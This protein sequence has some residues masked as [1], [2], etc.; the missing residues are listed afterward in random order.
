[1][2]WKALLCA[3]A[4]FFNSLALGY[5]T[6]TSQPQPERSTGV[7]APVRTVLLFPFK[8]VA[9]IVGAVTSFPVYWLSGFDAT[10]EADT[11]TVRGFYCSPQYLASPEW[12]K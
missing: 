4:L 8:G 3:F 2:S 12:K 5:A 7:L 10:V 6:E 11:S 9:C 1:M